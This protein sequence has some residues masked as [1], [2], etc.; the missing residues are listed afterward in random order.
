MWIKDGKILPSAV[1]GCPLCV[2]NLY[3][4]D[5]GSWFLTLP[6]RPDW[7]WSSRGWPQRM[8]RPR[9]LW[10]T[11][12]LFSGCCVLICCP[13]PAS[14]FLLIHYILSSGRQVSPEPVDKEAAA[15]RRHVS[16]PALRLPEGFRGAVKQMVGDECTTLNPSLCHRRKC[17]IAL[18]IKK[19]KNAEHNTQRKRIKTAFSME[20]EYILRW[21][22]Q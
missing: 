12:Y 19:I 6:L 15:E 7:P 3:W 8:A 2:W 14:T 22:S 10:V 13:D 4:W 21:D 16:I 11:K 9:D 20:R 5:Q 18:A 17:D 1:S